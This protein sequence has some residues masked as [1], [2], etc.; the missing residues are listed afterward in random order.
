MFGG[1][2]IRTDAIRATSK[3]ALKLSCLEACGD[4]IDMAE[5]AYKFLS[6]DIQ[7]LPDFDI[8]SPTIYQQIKSG[9]GEVFG[10]VKDNKD[11]IIQA[12]SYI[13]ALRSKPAPIAPQVD[14]PPIEK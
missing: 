2:K 10:F 6:S 13:Q 4:D 3:L 9:A 11:D 7:D 8:P 12:I 14:L 5:R 1:K